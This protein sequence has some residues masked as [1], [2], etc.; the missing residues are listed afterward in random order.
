M[1]G[2]EAYFHIVSKD[3]GFDPLIQHLKAK[4]I[5]ASRSKDVTEIPIVKAAISKTPIDRLSEGARV[6]ELGVDEL[7]GGA[8]DRFAVSRKP[9]PKQESWV[10][11]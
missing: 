5:L 11:T 6:Y 4:K 7:H 1:A 8:E 9:S 10:C 3:T 2:Q